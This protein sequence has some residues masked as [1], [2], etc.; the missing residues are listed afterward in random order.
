MAQ[1]TDGGGY[2]VVG[3]TA[4]WCSPADLD[5]ARA[6]ELAA[7]LNARG[8]GIDAV[9]WVGPTPVRGATWRPAGKVD[10]WIRHQFSYGDREWLG[11]VT[12][13]SGRVEWVRAS[14]LRLD[15]RHVAEG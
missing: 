9:R 10:V 13:E 14:E 4:D 1:R 5:E 12:D 2:G 15:D 8:A 3:L 6:T 7:E 11:R